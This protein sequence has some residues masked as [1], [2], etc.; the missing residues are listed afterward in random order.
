ME[1]MTRERYLNV[2]L[3]LKEMMQVRWS[4]FV[5]VWDELFPKLE[6][7]EKWGCKCVWDAVI[8]Y[9]LYSKVSQE[10]RVLWKH[11]KCW[12]EWWK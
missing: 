1:L 4:M 2:V 5:C 10:E 3:V 7:V 8:F 12:K 9:D 11:D 6:L